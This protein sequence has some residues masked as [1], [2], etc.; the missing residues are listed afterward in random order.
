MPKILSAK[1]I[2]GTNTPCQ[3]YYITP[4]HTRRSSIAR[5]RQ[6]SPS[7]SEWKGKSVEDINAI[8]KYLDEASQALL[9]VD[10][11]NLIIHNRSYEHMTQ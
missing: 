7:F 3:P 10:G 1:H 6:R 2:E 8:T 9:L 5:I 11:R 4:C